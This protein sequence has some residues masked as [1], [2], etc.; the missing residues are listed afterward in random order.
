MLLIDLLPITLFF[1]LLLFGM[2][3][4]FALAIS[5]AVGMYL[6]LGMDATL[7]MLQALPYRT[8]ASFVLVSIGMFILMAE[9]ASQS[10]ITSRLFGAANAFVGH[11]RGGLGAATILASA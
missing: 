11:F 2:A 6:L 4:A 1:V 8:T 9:L 7:G 3:V 10:G 5:G